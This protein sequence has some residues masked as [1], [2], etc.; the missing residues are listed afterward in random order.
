MTIQAS[1][2]VLSDD[3]RTVQVGHTESFNFDPP[4]D[5]VQ[6]GRNRPILCYRAD[7]NG[8]TSH[9]RVETNGVLQNNL[10]FASGHS[11]SYMEVITTDLNKGVNNITFEV[12]DDS[13]ATIN[14][15]DVII[16]FKRKIN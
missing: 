1:Y 16:L 4:N 9:L 5:I 14:I 15:S 6:D 8:S 7:P 11:Y 13:A 2:H 12:P 3:P 10:N